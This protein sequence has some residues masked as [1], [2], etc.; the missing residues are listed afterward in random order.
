MC[1][2]SF[3]GPLEITDGIVNC[4]G[5]LPIKGEVKDILGKD[6]ISF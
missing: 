3:K 5:I 6:E 2:K 1:L 4:L